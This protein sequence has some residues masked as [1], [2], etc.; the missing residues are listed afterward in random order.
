[1]RRVVLACALL[2]A[3][4][5]S[6][7]EPDAVRTTTTTAPTY[8]PQF[9]ERPCT[10]PVPDDARFECGTLTVPAD[11][12]APGDGDVVLPVMILRS[13]D[14]SALPDPIV[15]I[16][17]GPGFAAHVWTEFFLERD[18]G[19][20]RD[21]ILMDQRGTGRA[22]PSL[23]CPELV[24]VAVQNGGADDP[25]VEDARVEA[26]M[27]AC[28][29]R[30]VAGGV[31]LTDYDTP[32]T[33]ADF[34]ELRIA[35]GLDEWNVWGHSYGT[36][37]T[38]ELLRS[39]PEGV[40]AVVLDS[41]LPLDVGNGP[42]ENTRLADDAFQR[43]FDGCAADPSCAAGFPAQEAD[44]RALVAEWEADPFPVRAFG[45]DNAEHDFLITG[46]DVLDGAWQ[47]FYDAALIPL[48]PSLTAQLRER[49]EAATAI[50]RPLLEQSFVQ[51]LDLS[52]AQQRW[53]DCADRGRFV[54]VA[55]P[56]DTDDP[57]LVPFAEGDEVDVCAA[58]GVDPLPAS[59]NELA[60]WDAPTLVLVGEYDPVTPVGDAERVAEHL[61][62]ATLLVLPGLAHGPVFA[63]ECV[64]GVLHAFVDAPGADAEQPCLAE[65]GPPAWAV[66]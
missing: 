61:P 50:V 39:H 14:P 9:A 45:P 3:C 66:P 18:F 62:N 55:E 8:E 37:V 10:E 23:D 17:G 38:Q 43:I 57:I 65:L 48:L 7:D 35:L 12:A 33:A 64:E 2:A 42:A 11:R 25:D 63:S 56:V 47:A 52:E 44:F 13:A 24:E 36:A 60:T 46:R 4:S 19:G 21:V 40:R 31:D 1:M 15:H 32:A 51:V 41:V 59:F 27:T 49:G 6:D 29:D 54:R 26:A 16:T 58:W 5:S 20:N 34:A 22:D 53:V 28:R 30:L